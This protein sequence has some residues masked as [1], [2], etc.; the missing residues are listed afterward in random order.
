MSVGLTLHGRSGEADL[1]VIAGG[2][3]GFLFISPLIVP[4]GHSIRTLSAVLL[5]TAC[6]ASALALWRNQVEWSLRF[7]VYGSWLAVTVMCI[8]VEGIRTPIAFAY[9]VII[10]LAGWLLGRRTAIILGLLTVTAGLAIALATVFHILQPIPPAP[11]LVTWLV[12]TIIVASAVSIVILV[13]KDRDN[14]IGSLQRLTQEMREQHAFHE[15]LVRAQ[16]DAGLGMFIILGGRIVYANDA[17]C[18]MF[19]Y[20]Q[21]EIKALPSYLD[22]VSYTHLTLPTSDLV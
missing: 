10:M 5:L 1:E 4:D 18:R 9:P 14:R 22:P 15:T 21:E 16:S 17:L 7:L 13:I 2:F 8:L 20:T 6:S 12:Q 3:T 19:G 11:P